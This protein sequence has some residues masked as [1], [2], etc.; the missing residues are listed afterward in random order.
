MYRGFTTARRDQ[1]GRVPKALP[2]CILSCEHILLATCYWFYALALSYWVDEIEVFCAKSV[3]SC[4]PL[5][6]APCPRHSASPYRGH[7]LHSH[8]EFEMQRSST[9]AHV[10]LSLLHY[11]VPGSKLTSMPAIKGTEPR[12]V[13]LSQ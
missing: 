8:W 7:S 4:Q 12:A 11:S 5:A 9:K 13:G 6:P 1:R 2:A 10:I 3:P